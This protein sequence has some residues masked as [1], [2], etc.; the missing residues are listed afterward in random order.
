M[1]T[2]LD[3]RYVETIDGLLLPPTPEG[4]ARFSRDAYHRMVETGLF[5]SDSRIELIDGEIYMM[6]PLGP[7][8]GGLISRL[9]DFY[10]K[11]LP[12]AFQCRIQVPVVVG[13]HSEPLPDLTI[14]Q[15]RSDD[16]RSEHPAPTDV[17]LL[18]EVAQSS[19]SFD[20]GSKLR[21]YASSGISEYWVVDVKR[22]AVLVHRN[23]VGEQYGD[24]EMVLCGGLI[25][26]L[27][28][29][30]CQLDVSWLFR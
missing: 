18:I 13:D 12:E 2:A 22:E 20:L 3:I 5:N 23:P 8:Q 25:A 29:P 10:I 6:L 27:A 21:L 15:R 4:R 9:A 19:L 14:V 1:A 16:Y 24:S 11:Q 7:S 30:G 17:V 28:V 26:P